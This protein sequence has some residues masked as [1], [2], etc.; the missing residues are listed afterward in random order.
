MRKRYVAINK[1]YN[2]IYFLT[3]KKTRG[4]KWLKSEMSLKLKL[5]KSL[6]V[7]SFLRKKL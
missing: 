4:H 6:L 7:R 2:M 1:Y 5:A 3:P